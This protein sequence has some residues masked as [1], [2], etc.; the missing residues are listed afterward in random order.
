MNRLAFALVSAAF[1]WTAACEDA[2]LP[3]EETIIGGGC[4]YDSF[5]TVATVAAIAADGGVAMTAADGTTFNL[6]YS[7][8][9]EI[10]LVPQ[11][12]PVYPVMKRTITEGTCAPVSFNLIRPPTD[13]TPVVSTESVDPP[14]IG[15]A[16]SYEAT[17]VKASI[18]QIAGGDV[19]LR[20]ASGSGFFLGLADFAAINAEPKPGQVYDIT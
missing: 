12:G 4:S 1:A 7:Q 2:P 16:C 19:E 20:E 14:V 18:V 9:T 13:I 10:G 15:G 11:F 6:R 3:P 17:E 8:F 5:E